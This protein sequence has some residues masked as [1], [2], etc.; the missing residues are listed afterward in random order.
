[1]TMASR[2]QRALGAVD[3]DQHERGH[4]FQSAAERY[5]L[6][7]LHGRV[8]LGERVTNADIE[9]LRSFYPGTPVA[10]LQR[11]AAAVNGGATARDRQDRLTAVWAQS[12]GIP[13]HR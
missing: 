9:R 3:L 11:Y 13:E 12:V 1:M 10:M 4:R 6:T 5:L 7:A 2:Y 8:G